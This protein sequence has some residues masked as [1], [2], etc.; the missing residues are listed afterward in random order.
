MSID[1]EIKQ[2]QLEEIQLRCKKLKIEMRR[3][4]RPWVQYIVFEWDENTQT[5]R[6]FDDRS[7]AKGAVMMAE[8]LGKQAR[9]EERRGVSYVETASPGEK[10]ISEDLPSGHELIVKVGKRKFKKLILE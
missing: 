10:M 5:Q 4:E 6:T 7:D 9:I 2:A 1:D 3:H 8:A